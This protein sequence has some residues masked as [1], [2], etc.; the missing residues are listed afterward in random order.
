MAGK[1]IASI[2]NTVPASATNGTSTGFW[3]LY[4]PVGSSFVISLLYVRYQSQHGSPATA[5]ASSPR[6]A[7]NLF[8]F[9]GTPSGTNIV[10]GKMDSSMS[11][12]GAALKSTQATS[13]VSLGALVR[14]FLPVWSRS[15]SSGGPEST[16]SH[17]EWKVDGEIVLRA[18]QGLVCYQPDAGSTSDVRRQNIDL[19]WKES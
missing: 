9:T 14:A 16:A 15:T 7:L 18:G 17:V 4:N 5:C 6:C 11:S 12:P 1:Y 19:Y 3:W 2:L 8:T 13:V 10:P